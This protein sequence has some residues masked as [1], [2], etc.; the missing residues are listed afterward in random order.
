MEP[1][2]G[3]NM[4]WNGASEIPGRDHGSGPWISGISEGPPEV[5][6]SCDYVR[7]SGPLPRTRGLWNHRTWQK[8]VLCTPY[9]SR[10]RADA[11]FIKCIK[12]TTYITLHT[13]HTLRSSVQGSRGRA[14]RRLAA[15]G[16]VAA[17]RA[18]ERRVSERESTCL[19]AMPSGLIVHLYRGTSYGTSVRQCIVK[20][21]VV[22]HAIR[23]Y[24]IES[25]HAM[26]C[27]ESRRVTQ[28]RIVARGVTRANTNYDYHYYCYY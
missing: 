4:I 15:E 16:Q 18:S 10:P 20:S 6:M 24:V 5:G 3:E 26:F 19:Q 8:A 23:S 11:T 28:R 9:P 25:R 2:S 27:N 1:P 13:L 21:C 14:P 7:D 22:F 12:C 17:P